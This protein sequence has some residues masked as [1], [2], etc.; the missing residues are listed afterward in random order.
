MSYLK[1]APQREIIKTSDFI[2]LPEVHCQRNTSKRIRKVVNM[3]KDK[4][5][6]RQIEVA[7]AEYPDGKRVILDGN[8]RAQAWKHYSNQVQVPDAVLA[9][10]YS[11][12]NDAEAVLLYQTFD[13]PDAVEN[14]KDK[15]YSALRIVWG[16]DYVNNSIASKRFEK[17]TIATA[18]KYAIRF[19]LDGGTG[20]KVRYNSK[21]INQQVRYLTYYTNELMIL[22]K[23]IA[24]GEANHW[25]GLNQANFTV[26][27]LVLKKYG[28]VNR[29]AVRALEKLLSA[30]IMSDKVY[31]SQANRVDPITWLNRNAS[32]HSW[33]GQFFQGSTTQADHMEQRLDLTLWIIDRYMEDKTFASVPKNIR[34]TVYKYYE[35]YSKRNKFYAVKTLAELKRLNKIIGIK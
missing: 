18:V 9:T 11:I 29:K 32:S 16:D 6:V 30:D 14:S 1:G 25:Q 22:D 27:L 2:N 28:A 34:N 33:Y 12:Q 35:R 10:V 31:S 17:G 20:K 26:A 24:K 4:P 19:C 23:L 3:L 5:S 8:T 13:S 7:V 15:Y 21:D